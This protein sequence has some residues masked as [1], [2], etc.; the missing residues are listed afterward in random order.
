MSQELSFGGDESEEYEGPQDAAS[1]EAPVE[2]DLMGPVSINLGEVRDEPVGVGWHSVEIE[3]AEA[4]LSAGQGLPSIFVMG[5]IDDESDPEFRRTVVWNLMLQGDGLLF[6]K[7]CCSALGMS[8]QLNYP[9]YQE[10]ADDLVSRSCEV[11]V[12]HR[13]Y[14]GELRTNVSNWRPSTPALVF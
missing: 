3:R 14:Q 1:E 12:K 5:R 9:S 13:P 8:E 2:F 11:L 10:M 6:T 4:K 7:R